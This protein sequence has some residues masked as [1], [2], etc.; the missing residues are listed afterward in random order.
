MSC[1][2][3]RTSAASAAKH[4]AATIIMIA[5]CATGGTAVNRSPNGAARGKSGLVPPAPSAVPG[6]AGMVV[7]TGPAGPSP[8]MAACAV[9]AVEVARGTSEDS[10]RDSGR[11]SGVGMRRILGRSSGCGPSG[12]AYP[13]CRS[14]ARTR[15]AA[16]PPPA[17]TQPV[18]SWHRERL[19]VYWTKRALR[20]LLNAIRHRHGKRRIDA[21]STDGHHRPNGLRAPRIDDATRKTGLNEVRRRP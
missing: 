9:A 5:A 10:E 11:D 12:S 15:P 18:P 14:V 6:T 13:T 21:P 1:D 8:A 20:S 16:R 7:A 19:T 4:P 17:C 3:T 2:R